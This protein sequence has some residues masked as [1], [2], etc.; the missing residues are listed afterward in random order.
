MLVKFA[1]VPT[2]TTGFFL[3]TDEQIIARKARE[4]SVKAAWRA[5]KKTPKEAEYL[6]N[7]RQDPKPHPIIVPLSWYGHKSKLQ[8]PPPRPS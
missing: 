7:R 5:F 4:K 2:N 6:A 1:G 3:E 8:N